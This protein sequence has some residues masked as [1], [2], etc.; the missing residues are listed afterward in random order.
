M[1]AHHAV[2]LLGGQRLSPLAGLAF[3]KKALAH[4]PF[5]EAVPALLL[6]QNSEGGAG[7]R[8]IHALARRFEPEEAGYAA[9]GSLR[10]HQHV[11]VT[12]HM[13]GG[14]WLRCP[15]FDM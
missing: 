10:L 4:A 12:D 7:D 8:A 5:L 2:D 15:A 1:G 9:E 14:A 13:Q 3:A 6:L 11:F